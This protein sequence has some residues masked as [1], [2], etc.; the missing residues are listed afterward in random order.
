MAAESMSQALSWRVKPLIWVAA[1]MMLLAVWL[2]VRFTPH[3]FLADD[4]PAL[5]LDTIVPKQFGQWRVDPSQAPLLVD[6]TVQKKLDSLY[7]QTLNRTYVND[8]GDHVMLS[9]AYGRNQNTESTAAHRPEFCY[10]AQGF[11]VSKVGQSELSLATHRIPTIRLDA[12]AGER[13][14]PIIY[15]V[16][17]GDDASLPGFRRK[18]HQLKYGLQ[19]LIVDGMLVRVSSIRLAS[20]PKPLDA[21]FELQERFL[22]EFEQALPAAERSRFFGS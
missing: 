20:N 21:E 12:R 17:L 16:T 6:P 7:T 10:S 18:L 15:W 1:A 13:R 2:A 5:V 4:R 8:A 9:I 11:V 19:G 14:E 3:H 22:R